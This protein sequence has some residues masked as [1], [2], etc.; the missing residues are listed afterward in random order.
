MLAAGLLVPLAPLA[1]DLVPVPK[2]GRVVDLTGTLTAAEQQELAARLEAFEKSRGAQVAVLLVASIGTETLE[3]FAGRVTDAWQLGR[4]GVDD[5]VLFVIAKGE[6]KMR[7]HTGRGVQG[8]LTDALAKRIVAERVA[9]RFRE[10]NFHG[11]IGAGVEAILKAIEGE[12]LP[13]PSPG[14]ARKSDRTTSIEDF[15]WIAFF[16]VPVVAMILRSLVGRLLGAGLTSGVTGSA[17]WW[18]FGSLAGA[19]VVAIMAFVYALLLGAGSI[20]HGRSASG[21]GWSGGGWSGGSGGSSWG[22]GGGFSG[23]GG[24]FDGGGA[25]GGW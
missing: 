16:A 1:Q 22:G 17:A 5:G 4:K 3:E 24:S 11:G 14:G 18:I 19:I 20:R 9:P 21:A 2:V 8:V 12:A 13:P 10:G 25:S 23:G 15:L 6:R 7:I